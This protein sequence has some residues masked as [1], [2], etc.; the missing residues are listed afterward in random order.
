MNDPLETYQEPDPLL[1]KERIV[2]L[3]VWLKERRLEVPALL[4]IDSLGPLSSIAT[5]GS[6]FFQ[7]CGEI[8]LGRD[9]YSLFQTL[10]RSEDFRAQLRQQIEPPSAGSVEAKSSLEHAA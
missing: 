10:L 9:R 2:A 8:L 7:Q 3:A 1:V 5:A 4:L 6:V